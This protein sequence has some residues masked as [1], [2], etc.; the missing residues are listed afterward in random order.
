MKTL[1]FSFAA[2]ALT[3]C[4][5]TSAFAEPNATPKTTLSIQTSHATVAV[6][7]G[8]PATRIVNGRSARATYHVRGYRGWTSYCW[9]PQYQCYGYYSS[10]DGLWYYWYAPM[11]RFQ[12]VALMAQY[13]PTPIAGGPISP[14]AGTPGLPGTPGTAGTLPIGTPPGG[15][16]PPGA[17]TV[18]AGGPGGMVPPSGPTTPGD[19]MPPPM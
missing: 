5:A 7:T 1:L 18:P 19:P 12:S 6:R 2:A 17:T 14:V 16:L 10:V 11:N 15:T 9:F 8:R 4:L 3:V 13:P